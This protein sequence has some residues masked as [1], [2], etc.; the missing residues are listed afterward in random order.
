M[1]RR[2]TT[3]QPPT[4]PL[5]RRS[6]IPPTL[7]P[8]KSS[9]SSRNRYPSQGPTHPPPLM[10]RARMACTSSLRPSPPRYP[11]RRRHP[12]SRA[13]GEV[14]STRARTRKRSLSSSPRQL[15]LRCSMPLGLQKHHSVQ[16]QTLQAI[17]FP[18]QM[19]SYIVHKIRVPHPFSLLLPRSMSLFL[20]LLLLFPTAVRLSQT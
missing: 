2:S 16:L 8:H 15:L 17:H 10:A 5:A 18:H 4:K 14:S 12:S 19:Y 3:L 9:Q 13:Q 1:R 7:T 20:L 11:R 6:T